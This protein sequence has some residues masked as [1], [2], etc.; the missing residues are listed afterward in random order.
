[1]IKATLADIQTTSHPT[2]EERL[3]KA[4]A[5][6]THSERI[7]VFQK[8]SQI[9][10]ASP[11]NI[12]ATSDQLQELQEYKYQDTLNY[13]RE[14]FLYACYLT[15]EIHGSGRTGNFANLVREE[16]LQRNLDKVKHKTLC[17]K[18][19]KHYH[20]IKQLR[21]ENVS[22]PSIAKY[23]KRTYGR[24]YQGYNITAS[25]LRRAYIKHNNPPIIKDLPSLEDFLQE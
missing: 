3:C 7:L 8:H 2:A 19:E 9:F 11:K 15:L 1:M 16:R 12:E 23:L 18:L 5:K 4:F 10:S 6:A 21:Q 22:W 24:Y 14:C 20:L 25:Y 13:S 17:E